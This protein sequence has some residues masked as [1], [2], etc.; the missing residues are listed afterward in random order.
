LTP[1]GRHHDNLCLSEPFL[2]RASAGASL[3]SAGAGLAH[4]HDPIGQ[5]LFHRSST[6]SPYQHQRVLI[7]PTGHHHGRRSAKHLPA[8]PFLTLPRRPVAVPQ[9][10]VLPF[11]PAPQRPVLC[12]AGC[13]SVSSRHQNKRL[14]SKHL[15]PSPAVCTSPADIV[16]RQTPCPLNTCCVSA[17]VES[18]GRPPPW[19]AYARL[20]DILPQILKNVPMIILREDMQGDGLLSRACI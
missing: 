9:L 12:H 20:S 6:R 16:T 8:H 7:A 17:A 18:I 3:A 1:T 2:Q 5:S 19:P 15:V 14:A 13:V 4:R 10:A 11:A